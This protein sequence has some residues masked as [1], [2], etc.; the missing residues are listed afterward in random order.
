LLTV[1]GPH[2][3]KLRNRFLLLHWI[4]RHQLVDRPI[5]VQPQ[6]GVEISGYGGYGAM[7]IHGET[8]MIHIDPHGGI[9]V[10]FPSRFVG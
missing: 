2:G 1:C 4:Q 8:P 5:P 3:L 10:D 7:E 9:M 6:A